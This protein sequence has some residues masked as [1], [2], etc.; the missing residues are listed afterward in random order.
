MEKILGKDLVE[1]S[2]IVTGKQHS[3]QKLSA[4]NEIQ[5]QKN[6][7]FPFLSFSN[8][9]T[10]FVTWLILKLQSKPDLQRCQDF[11]QCSGEKM[12]RKFDPVQVVV[13]G[14]DNVTGPSNLVSGRHQD[15]KKDS[16]LLQHHGWDN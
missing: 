14:T 16:K 4:L 7:P 3:P 11:F 8:I 6:K 5:Q 1:D 15:S 12:V 2:V 10:C 9:Q 13:S